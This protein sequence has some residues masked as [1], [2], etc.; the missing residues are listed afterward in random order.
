MAFD[1]DGVR[2]SRIFLLDG[3]GNKLTHSTQ[4]P[5]SPITEELTSQRER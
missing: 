3:F 4:P 5:T 2:G 1:P